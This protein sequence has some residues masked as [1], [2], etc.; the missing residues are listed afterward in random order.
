LRTVDIGVDGLC[1]DF[2]REFCGKL[3]LLFLVDRTRRVRFG[4][5]LG[6][7]HDDACVV[8]MDGKFVDVHFGA[9]LA[10]CA[11]VEVAVL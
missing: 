8:V 10:V 3:L 1:L 4:L 9:D 6:S 11:V 5:V 2:V 7:D